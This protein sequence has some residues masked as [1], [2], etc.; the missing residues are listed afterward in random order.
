MEKGSPKTELEPH[1][2]PADYEEFLASLTAVEHELHEMG[3]EKLGSSYFVERTR[4][5]KKWIASRE[6]NSK[7]AKSK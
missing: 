2:K 5:Y 7:E 4:S 1:P 6:A 3:Q